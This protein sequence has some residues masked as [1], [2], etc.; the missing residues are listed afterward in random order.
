[1]NQAINISYRNYRFIKSHFFVP[2]LLVSERIPQSHRHR[3]GNTQI[4]SLLSRKF[5]EE[6]VSKAASGSIT[7]A[8]PSSPMGTLDMDSTPPAQST[9]TILI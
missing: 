7:Q 3:F 2:M 6:K 4:L 5:L 1:M 8:E 9:Q